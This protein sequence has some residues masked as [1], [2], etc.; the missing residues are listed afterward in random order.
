MTH[1]GIIGQLIASLVAADPAEPRSW[2]A[3]GAA[4]ALERRGQAWLIAER[5]LPEGAPA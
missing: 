2:L 1:G 3:A 4:I 5:I